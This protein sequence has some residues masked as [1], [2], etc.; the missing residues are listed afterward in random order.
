LP[1][2]SAQIKRILTSGW[3]SLGMVYLIWSTTYLAV[4]ITVQPGSGFPPFA[5]GATRLFVAFIILLLLARL[6]KNRLKLTSRELV[7]AALT[8]LLLWTGGSGLVNWAVQSANSGF[9]ALMAASQPIWVAVINAYLWRQLPSGLRMGSLI[10]GFLGVAMLM[11]PKIVAGSH[12]ESVATLALLLS[13]LSW[14]V[15]S[16]CQTRSQVRIPVL[17]LSAYQALFGALG[18]LVLSLLANEPIPDPTS[19]AWLAWGYLIIFGSVLGYTAFIHALQKLPITI[20]MTYSYVNPILALLLGWWVLNEQIGVF[21]LIGA[22]MIVIGVAGLF[23]EHN[24]DQAPSN[25]AGNSRS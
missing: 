23:H 9:A 5:M 13:A 24:N 2:P 4:R 18:T 15:G 6:N 8:G 16:V 1:S 22:I 20:A 11:V 7:V 3:V 25:N 21:T 12:T 17:V 10:L 19:S 14:S